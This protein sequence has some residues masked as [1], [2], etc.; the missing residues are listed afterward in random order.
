MRMSPGR[1]RH[2]SVGMILG[3]ALCA[4][5]DERQPAQRAISD[6]DTRLNAAAP[7]A[8]RYVP[9]QLHQV[10]DAL[11][12]LRATYQEQR[13]VTVI[14]K[15]P[16][17]MSAAQA[18]GAAAAARKAAI[19]A[20]LNDQW[21]ALASAVTVDAAAIQNRLDGLAQ[22][23]GK[24]PGGSTELDAARAGLSR[25]ASLWSK[26]QAAFAT[27][28]MT[29]AVAIATGVKSNLETLAGSIN[30]DL[31]APSAQGTPTR[32]LRAPKSPR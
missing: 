24:H 23:S 31:A 12:A 26:A 32:H 17:V 4:C 10:Q 6:I 25:N 13:Y 9:E 29:E 14:A 8:A 30:L 27:G 21:T 22:R 7:E 19:E 16:G 20:A 5:A 18:L 3:L 2:Y 1:L 28:N 11:E 15:A